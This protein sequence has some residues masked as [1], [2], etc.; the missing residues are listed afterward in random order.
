M[1]NFAIK[2]SL[3]LFLLSLTVFHT[4]TAQD[5]NLIADGAE[6]QLQSDQFSFTEGPAT[7]SAGN[8]FFTDQP[9]NS[10]W[11][12]S[13]E[14]ELSLFM[15][16]AGRSNGMFFDGNG[17]L[18]ACADERIEI[19]S[20]TPDGDVTV[21]VSDFG[22]LKLNGPNDLWVHDNGGIYFTDPYYQREYWERS[23]KEIEEER[24]Y[25]ITP[26]RSEVRVAADHYVK[27]N[28]II[29]TPDG[30]TLY[31][32]DIGDR[33]T[34]S[35]TIQSDGSLTDRKLFTELGSDGMTI[36]NQGNVYLTGNGV[37]VFDSGGNQ[38]EHIEVPENWTANVAFG[39]ADHKTLFITAMSGVYTLRMNVEGVR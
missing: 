24:V 28:G 1:A 12:Y 10:I 7:D 37:T 5:N 32:A 2:L 35:Y 4:V 23:E 15:E 8:I 22:G 31:V 21:V 20:I 14:G 9:N 33:K 13:T 27:P 6:L 19:W 39:G 29:G 34:Y 11:K 3:C 25:Y 18:L 17:N 16:D 38:I 30:R 36:D 26:D